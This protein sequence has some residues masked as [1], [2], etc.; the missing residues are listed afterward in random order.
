MYGC[1]DQRNLNRHRINTESCTILVSVQIVKTLQHIALEHNLR[2]G[3]QLKLK[4][5]ALTPEA[6]DVHVRHAQQFLYT[7]IQQVFKTLDQFIV[8]RAG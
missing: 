6:F 8:L 7:T 3:F 4:N 5:C 2:K 1:S